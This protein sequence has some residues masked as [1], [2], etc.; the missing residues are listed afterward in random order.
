MEL[1][2]RRIQKKG[3]GRGERIRQRAVLRYLV[4]GWVLFYGRR[5]LIAGMIGDKSG[6][7]KGSHPM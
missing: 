5:V 3:F 4:W 2:V 6:G 1:G 7:E